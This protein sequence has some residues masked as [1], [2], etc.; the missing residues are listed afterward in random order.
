MTRR[1]RLFLDLLTVGVGFLFGFLVL[2]RLDGWE[3]KPSQLNRA[4]G[5]V[6]S[7]TMGIPET[8]L[9]PHRGLRDVV[10]KT[11]A[12]GALDDS[13]PGHVVGLTVPTVPRSV[14]TIYIDTVHQD[15]VWVLAH[16]LL[17]HVLA[18]ETVWGSAHPFVPFAFPCHLMGYQQ[19]GIGIMG[20]GSLRRPVRQ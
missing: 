1:E 20:Q 17:H 7:C 5:W 6:Q 8:M 9:N 18:D 10:W 3:P 14:D 19:N 16:E 13:A 4:W 15:T 12:P 2:G 11:F